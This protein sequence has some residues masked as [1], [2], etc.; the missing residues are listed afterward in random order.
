MCKI[1]QKHSAAEVCRAESTILYLILTRAVMTMSAV[2]MVD[3]CC[4]GA[5][6]V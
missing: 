4:F 1:E 5:M 2:F 6:N 3:N